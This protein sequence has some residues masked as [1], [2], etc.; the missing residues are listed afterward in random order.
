MSKARIDI[1]DWSI[2]TK[3]GGTSDMTLAITTTYALPLIVIW[4]VL[5][6]GVASARAGAKVS[7]GDGGNTALLLKIRR[8]GNF[9][10]WVPFVLILMILAEAQGAGSLWLHGAGA[11]LLIGRIVHPF[12]LKVENGEHPLRM[13]GNTANLLAVLVLAVA[14]IRIVTG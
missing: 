12:G 3:K 6:I 5:W 8:H 1:R 10:E 7:I 9:I 4:F 14:L 2:G 13:A 11:L